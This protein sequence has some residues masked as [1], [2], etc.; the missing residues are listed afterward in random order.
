M[1]EELQLA[2]QAQREILP[3]QLPTMHGVSVAALWRPAQYVSGDI[4]DVIRLDDDH[5]GLFLADAVGHGVAAAL[6][7][8]VI[9]RS[10][11]TKVAEGS[12]WRILE[13]REVL[14]QLN[15]QMLGFKV[16]SSRFATA[17][18]AVVDCRTRRMAIAVA[19]HPPPFLLHADGRSD[20][21]EASG[22]LLGVF[23]DE[24]Y[25]QVEVQ[26]KPGDRLLL[27]TDGFEQAFPSDGERRRLPT[28]R[29]RE[30]V[31]QLS[32]AKSPEDMIDTIRRRL[33][34]QSGSLHQID[35][36]TLICV[37]AGTESQAEPAPKQIA[38]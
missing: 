36:L 19:G 25:D 29:Y 22:G 37:Q 16:Q 17:V 23:D 21:L 15:E 38:A 6:M 12:L 24:V 3:R 8:M 35:D 7:T 18:Y 9:A 31:M 34:V 1:H 20:A 33:D 14:G 13:P 32:S 11:I 10:L 5:L 26:L 30:E 2:A 4:Y 28:S 27:Y